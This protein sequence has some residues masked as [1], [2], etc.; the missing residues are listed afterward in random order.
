MAAGFEVSEPAITPYFV[1]TLSVGEVE[2]AFLVV[3]SLEGEPPGRA[4]RVLS[5]LLAN[6]ADLIRFL[7]LLLGNVDEALYQ[8]IKASRVLNLLTG[9]F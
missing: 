8:A 2:S 3:C 7:L 5:S 6:R 4:E 9:S 1:L